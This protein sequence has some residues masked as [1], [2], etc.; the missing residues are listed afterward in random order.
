VIEHLLRREQLLERLLGRGLP[1]DPAGTA[2]TLVEVVDFDRS[3]DPLLD[4]Q[5]ATARTITTGTAT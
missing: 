1:F 5:L 2:T 4:E 3:A